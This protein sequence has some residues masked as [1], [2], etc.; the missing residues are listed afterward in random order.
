MGHRTAGPMH[1]L[2]VA[3]QRVK[4]GDFSVRVHWRKKD[5]FQEIAGDF[6]E[7]MESI[8]SKVET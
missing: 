8:Q 3:F 6:N 2:S 4:S 7:M 5:D 1:Q